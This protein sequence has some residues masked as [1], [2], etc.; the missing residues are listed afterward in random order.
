MEFENKIWHDF[1][2][3][4]SYALS[5]IYYQ[6][7]QSL[8]RLGK[9]FTQ[10][11][12]LIKDTIQDLFFDLIRTRQN[13]G[14]TDN[15]K[16]YLH[17][18][19]RRKLFRNIKKRGIVSNEYNETEP[20]ANIIYSAEREIINKEELTERDKSIKKALDELTPKQREIL[21]YKYTCGFNYEQICEIMSLKYDS[22]RKQAYRALKSLKRCLDNS[23]I[24]VF[25]LGHLLKR[26]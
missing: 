14:S 5:H 1:K 7:I 18:S 25:F 15:V 13:L 17:T 8:F 20:D 2:K 3:G 16:L 10:S 4:E 6:N 19:F 11:D 22:A 12:E 21:Y 9:K 26:S 24:I 23:N